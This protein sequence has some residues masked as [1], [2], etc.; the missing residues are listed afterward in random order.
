MKLSSKSTRSYIP[1]MIFAVM[2]VAITY[3]FMYSGSLEFLLGLAIL[4]VFFTIKSGQRLDF[5][6]KAIG[7]SPVRNGLGIDEDIIKDLVSAAAN[8]RE[9][10]R[11]AI[12][13]VLYFHRFLFRLVYIL[14]FVLLFG[15]FYFLIYEN[16]DILKGISKMSKIASLSVFATFILLG[17]MWWCRKTYPPS[18]RNDIDLHYRLLSRKDWDE[19]P[20]FNKRKI[21][22][23]S[24][25]ENE[26]TFD[27]YWLREDNNLDDLIRQINREQ[28]CF[29]RQDGKWMLVQ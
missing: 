29:E 7:M 12:L 17:I 3:A 15:S 4:T 9:N 13:S 14:L 11:N 26:K 10:K 19:N 16:D 22:A 25:T 28:I 23:K 5:W 21:V 1:F 27:S 2:I 20:V 18:L 6:L 24:I 8:E